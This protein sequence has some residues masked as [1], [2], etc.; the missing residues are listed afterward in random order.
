M[1]AYRKYPFPPWPRDTD[2]DS[3]LN[4]ELILMGIFRDEFSKCGSVYKNEW[5]CG[6]VSFQIV[7]VCPKISGS[8]GV[9]VFKLV[10]VCPKMSGSVGVW[11]WKWVG[12]WVCRVMKNSGKVLFGVGVWECR[13]LG[14]SGKVAYIVLT[15]ATLTD[16]FQ[17]TTIAWISFMMKKK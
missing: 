17:K 10:G 14:N 16:I 7:G 5:E 8:V 9:W 6:S 12:V 13:V 1:F 3:D 11:V 4:T 2:L 15:I